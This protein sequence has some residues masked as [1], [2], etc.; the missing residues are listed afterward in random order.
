MKVSLSNN[1]NRD[2]FT[3]IV[4]TCVAQTS[5]EPNSNPEVKEEEE[6]DKKEV[7]VENK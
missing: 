7:I 6:E 4:R 2:L 5:S 1:F 3:L